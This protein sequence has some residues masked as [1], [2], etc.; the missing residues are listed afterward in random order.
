MSVEGA[1][2]WKRRFSVVLFCKSCGRDYECGN[3]SLSLDQTAPMTRLAVVAVPE[4]CP[5]CKS[6]EVVK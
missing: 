2:A 3:V 4:V 6:L 5:T 1:D